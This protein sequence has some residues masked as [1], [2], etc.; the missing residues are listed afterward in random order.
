MM[1]AEVRF[2]GL[3]QQA[4]PVLHRYASNRGLPRADADDLVARTLEVAWR[5]IDD[6]P[7]DDPLPWLYAVAR[8]LWRNQTRATSRREALL[9]RLATAGAQ[10]GPGEN[11][12][13]GLDS[14]R[15]ALGKL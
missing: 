4:F 1:D 10:A 9:A 14:L 12:D 11:G 2:R 7:A 5:R 13:M 6:I 3:F 8:N 15:E